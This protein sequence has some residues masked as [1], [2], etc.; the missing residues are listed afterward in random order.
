M[1]KASILIIDDEPINLKLAAEVLKENYELHFSRNGSDALEF[2][3]EHVPDLILLDITMPDMSGFDVVEIL[4]QKEFT[5]NIPIIYLT[6]D[7]SEQ[8]IEKAFDTGAIDYIAKPFRSKELKT[9]VKNR[10]ETEKLKSNL[11]SLLE[12]NKHLLK[13]MHTQVAYIKTDTKGIMTEISP[14]MHKMIHSDNDLIGQNISILKTD[15]TPSNQYE[16]LWKTIQNAKIYTGKIENRNF[17]G[18]SNWYSITIVPDIDE[19]NKIQ[20]Y[21]AFYT[22]IDHEVEYKNETQIDYLTNIYNRKKF[23]TELSREIYLFKRYKQSF[24]LIIAD[25]DFFKSVNDNYG[26]DVGDIILIEF[27]Q[28]LL[29]HLRQS[30]LLAR[31]GGEEFVILCRNSDI[32]GASALAELLKER[33]Q[34]YHFERI[35]HKTASF[36][37]AQYTQNMDINTLIKQADKALYEAKSQGRNRVIAATV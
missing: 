12:K 24:S 32:N 36:G 37:V 13:I 2:L 26:H 4:K 9:R 17:E 33:L 30:D 14:A 20:S 23:E 1:D 16:Q 6:A 28:L 31:W 21:Y 27:S 25:I 8:T 10:I 3:Q 5:Q 15:A 35:G 34:T 29:Q 22:N 7:N 19:K 18:G 11:Q